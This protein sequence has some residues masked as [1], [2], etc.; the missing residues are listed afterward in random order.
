MHRFVLHNDDIRDSHEKDLAA[1]QAGLMNGWGVFSTIRVSD[2]VLFAY[3][4]HWERMQ[5]DAAR[6]HVPFPPDG[7]GLKS[8]PLNLGQANP[9]GSATRRG[10]VGGNRVGLV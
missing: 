6:M 3:E 4:R 10:V 1:G 7:A 5:R 9:A 8:R 2:G